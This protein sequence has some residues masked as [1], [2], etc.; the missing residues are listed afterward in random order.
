MAHKTIGD[1]NHTSASSA[2]ATHVYDGI[3]K[4]IY[5]AD[6]HRR[7]LFAR[8]NEPK[9]RWWSSWHDHLLDLSEAKQRADAN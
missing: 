1:L 4:K 2:P 6:T 9:G 3:F 5:P 7:L 8:K